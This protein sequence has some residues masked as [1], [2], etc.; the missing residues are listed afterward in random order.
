MKAM[1]FKSVMGGICA[2][3]FGAMASTAMAQNVGG[4]F[5]PAV[6]ADDRQL[7]FRLGMAP[8]ANDDWGAVAR[9]H[10]QH[11]LNDTVRLRGVVQYADPANGD[12][13]L[14][15]FQVELLWQTVERTESG[16]VS[17]IRFDARLSEGDDGASKLGANWIHDLNFGEGWRARGIILANIDV[18]ARS[19]DGVN[20]GLRS[21]LT[22]RL[23]NGLRVGVEQFSNLGN[24]DAGFGRFDEQRHSVGPMIA[25]SVS[26]EWGWYA[27]LQLGVSERANDHDWQIRLTRRY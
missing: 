10:Y 22:R 27:G 9:L 14:K 1:T 3:L 8:D 7:E 2:W 21:S 20:L 25:G 13:E 6:N 4:V 12:L 17:G 11:A 26:D 16:Y 19:R 5:G 15:H 18:G 24:S 23:D